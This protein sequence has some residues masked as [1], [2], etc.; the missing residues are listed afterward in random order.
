M[1][2][3][4]EKTLKSCPLTITCTPWFAHAPPPRRHP[5]LLY[6]ISWSVFLPPPFDLLLL[7]VDFEL[8]Q[9]PQCLFPRPHSVLSNW[10]NV[11]GCVWVPG[12]QAGSCRIS[13]HLLGRWCKRHSSEQAQ[14]CPGICLTLM[15]WVLPREREVPVIKQWHSP[16]AGQSCGQKSSYKQVPRPLFYGLYVSFRLTGS[17]PV[18]FKG[19]SG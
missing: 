5:D 7:K 13:R 4:R 18:D 8:F 12:E 10:K 6:C 16:L 2:Q 15:K 9:I 14:G 17:Q 19:L 3:R 11:R 1:V